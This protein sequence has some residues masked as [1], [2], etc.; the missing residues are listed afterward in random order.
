MS[1]GNNWKVQGPFPKIAIIF[2]SPLSGLPLRDSPPKPPPLGTL[3]SAHQTLA[4]DAGG[5]RELSGRRDVD[6]R[7]FP[8]LLIDHCHRHRQAPRHGEQR[9]GT[10]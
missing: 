3:P 2:S 1:V 5:G 10:Q 4:P 7:R 8:L 6:Q 9:R